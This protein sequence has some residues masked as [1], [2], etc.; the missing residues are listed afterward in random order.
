M[1]FGMPILEQNEPLRSFIFLSAQMF[2]FA[3]TLS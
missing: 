1:F 2:V 3:P